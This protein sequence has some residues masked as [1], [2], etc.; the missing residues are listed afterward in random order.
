METSDEFVKYKS[1]FFSVWKHGQ[2]RNRGQKIVIANKTITKAD[3]TIEPCVEH[4]F[5]VE[6]IGRVYFHDY[7]QLLIVLFNGNLHIR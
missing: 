7:I 6:F 1:Y 2:P 4:H 3:L 5:A